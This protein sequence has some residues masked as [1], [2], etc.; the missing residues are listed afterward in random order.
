MRGKKPIHDYD[1]V[2]K[3]AREL[4]NEHGFQKTTIKM[5]AD[6]ARVSKGALLHHFKKYDLYLKTRQE[7][8]EHSGN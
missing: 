5:I 6:K 7:N 1:N 4:F 8:G 3:V 2:I